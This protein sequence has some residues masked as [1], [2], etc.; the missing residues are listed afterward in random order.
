MKDKCLKC[1][2]KFDEKDL[3]GCNQCDKFNLCWDC[4][5]DAEIE[6]A[7]ELGEWEN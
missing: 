2:R 6:Q 3:L 4:M 1:R 5:N 7:K